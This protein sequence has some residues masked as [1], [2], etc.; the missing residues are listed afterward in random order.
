MNIN[1]AL[2]DLGVTDE[3]LTAIQKEE[4]DK[5][6]FTI[7]PEIIDPLWLSQLRDQFEY[8]CDKEG[9]A[10]GMEVHQEAGTRRLADLVNKGDVFDNI[11]TN[12]ALLAAVYRVIE[13]EFKLGS[14]NSRDAL[15]GEGHQNLH[16]DRAKDYSK[17]YDGQ[18]HVC[19]SLWLLDDFTADNGPTRLV[20]GTH[21]QGQPGDVLEDLNAPHPDEEYIIAPA[22]SV[23]VFNAH[24]WHGGTLN[25]THG[26]RRV[27]HCYFTAREHNQ[28]LDQ[29]EYI[30]YETWKR[31]SS[32]ARY[33]LDVDLD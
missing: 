33:I 26:K 18:F 30:R 17:T 5:K 28:Q 32:A 11:Y 4:L 2:E 27:I 24:V 15:P 22:G 20:P 6:G 13:G 3:S 21:F 29:R 16:T 8:L 25:N 31:I 10:A 9:S 14:L 19:N 7:L 12:P 23:A 1:L